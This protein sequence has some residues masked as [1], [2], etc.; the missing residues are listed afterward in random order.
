MSGIW[1]RG[2]SDGNGRR[3]AVGNRHRDLSA[4]RVCACGQPDDVGD[5]TFWSV[6][7]ADFPRAYFHTAALVSADL[8]TWWPGSADPASR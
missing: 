3:G 5:G 7:V 4:G 6:K 8:V 1:T 2:V